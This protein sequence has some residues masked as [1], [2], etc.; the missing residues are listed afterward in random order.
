MRTR[1]LV[2]LM[3]VMISVSVAFAQRWRNRTARSKPAAALLTIPEAP[4]EVYKT[5][6]DVKLKMYI[7][8]PDGHKPTDRRPTRLNTSV[9]RTL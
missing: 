5:A 2:G 9:R 4:S 1:W 3:V 8:N 6:G 7:F